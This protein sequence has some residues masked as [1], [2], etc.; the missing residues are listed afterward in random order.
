MSTVAFHEENGRPLRNIGFDDGEETLLKNVG[1]NESGTTISVNFGSVQ[2]RTFGTN[3]YNDLVNKPSIEGVILE[4]NT[5]LSDLS[6]ATLLYH[7]EA[8]WDAQPA[9]VTGEGIIYVYSDHTTVVDPGGEVSVIPAIK[10]GDGV[11]YLSDL[12]FIGG[13][14]SP[15]IEQE[16][17]ELEADVYAHLANDQIHVSSFDRTEWNRK[18]SAVQDADNPEM[19]IIY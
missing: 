6:A 15:E 17:Q 4:G 11:S 8:E 19:L 1:L 16:L 7:T 2:T 18:V 14:A 13:G 5:S 9:L 10:I 12:P 3:N